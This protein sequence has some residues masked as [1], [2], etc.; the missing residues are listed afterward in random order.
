VHLLDTL[1]REGKAGGPLPLPGLPM[2]PGREVA[3]IIDE[4]GGD[5]DTGLLGRAAV[6]DLGMASGGYAELALAEVGSLH[7]L[8]PGLS[9]DD[10]VTM[11][12]TGRTAMAILETAAPTADDIVLVTAAAGG[13]GTLLVQAARAAGAMVAGVARGNRKLSLV[14][15]LGASAAAD[16]SQPG[17]P[18][19]VRTAL[20]RP[21]TLALDG[22]GGQIGRA[23]L[24]L[25]GVGG[26]LVMFGSAAGTLT[27]LTA[28][29]L[30]R[31][32]ITASAAIGARLI[33]RQGGLH[34]LEARALTAAAEGLL[35]PVVG[36]RFALADAA[37]AHRA[38]ASRSTIG[39]TVLHPSPQ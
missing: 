14:R 15:E 21:V 30:Y 39:K 10:A 33:R 35:T 16:Y 2:T 18:D 12:G 34:A 9:A 19:E 38:I 29:D 8:P 23:A 31:R 7:V 3:G 25:L 32:G 17:W 5:V 26:R 37:T 11:I 20:G 24:E 22:V 36:Q 13:I 6:A 28:D 1:I 27:E 4:V